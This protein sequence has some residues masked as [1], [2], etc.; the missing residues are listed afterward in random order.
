[1]NLLLALHIAGLD[2]VVVLAAA[3]EEGAVAVL[4]PKMNPVEGTCPVLVDTPEEPP[5]EKLC[6]PVLPPEGAGAVILPK[7]NPIEDAGPVLVDT[8][9]EP[10]KEKSCGHVLP[11]VST[12]L[13]AVEPT[14]AAAVATLLLLLLLVTLLEDG[15]VETDSWAC[16][17]GAGRLLFCMFSSLTVP[18]WKSKCCKTFLTSIGYLNRNIGY[19]GNQFIRYS[20]L[21]LCG[22][23]Y[24]FHG[25]SL[26]IRGSCLRFHN[27]GQRINRILID[28]QTFFEGICDSRNILLLFRMTNICSNPSR[29]MIIIILKSL[30]APAGKFSFG[31]F[32]SL[33]ASDWT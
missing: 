30:P 16:S 25:S 18:S 6:G 19:C 10:P 24:S 2:K 33:T 32:S 4:P 22:S 1:L 3:A 11:P 29:Y 9:E 7:L 13:P 15:V 14:A 21:S 5:K 23:K 17:G 28:I 20:F 31:M 26:S 12:L 27:S 8:S